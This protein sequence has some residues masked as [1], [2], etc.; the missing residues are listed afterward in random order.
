[1]LDEFTHRHYTRWR[2]L[3]LLL[4]WSLLEGVGYRQLTVFWRLRGLLGFA[5]GRSEWGVM[6]RRGFTQEGEQA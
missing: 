5:R 6:S 4:L 2:D 3:P 1:M